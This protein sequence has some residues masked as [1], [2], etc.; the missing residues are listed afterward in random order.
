[1]NSRSGWAILIV[2]LAVG[3][4][5]AKPPPPVTG[6]AAAPCD[7]NRSA[8]EGNSSW[9]TY[10]I[11]LSPQPVAV[12]TPVVVRLRFAAPN[13]AEAT[14]DLA[15]AE[16]DMGPNLVRLQRV[17]ASTRQGQMV[18]P[19]CLTGPMRWRLTLTLREGSRSES[20]TYDFIAPTGHDGSRS[21][22]S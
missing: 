17:D 12:L 3:C 19:M 6:S 8:C 11:A 13:K 10:S 16:M 22:Q 7:L 18:I 1:M 14:V 5:S 2:M 15:G 9:G 20:M 4:E 21:G